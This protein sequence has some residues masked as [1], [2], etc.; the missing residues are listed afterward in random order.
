MSK[1]LYFSSFFSYSSKT[2]SGIKTV[3][4]FGNNSN[5]TFKIPT[6]GLLSY[7][8]IKILDSTSELKSLDDIVEGISS[9]ALTAS[10]VNKCLQSIDL[11]DIISF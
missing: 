11:L 8:I 5:L 6:G 2:L 10:D 4:P 3:L 7:L 1:L 9:L